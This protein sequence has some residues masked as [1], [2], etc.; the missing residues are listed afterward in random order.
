MTKNIFILLFYELPLNQIL[1]T[2]HKRWLIKL[3][4]TYNTGDLRPFRE[5]QKEH[6]IL[7]NTS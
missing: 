3:I 5:Y 4:Q 7:I 2:Y 1:N 6:A